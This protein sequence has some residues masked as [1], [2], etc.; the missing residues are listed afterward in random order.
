MSHKPLGEILADLDAQQRRELAA[1]SKSIDEAERNRVRTAKQSLST[2]ATFFIERTWEEIAPRIDTFSLETE[3]GRSTAELRDYLET[4]HRRHSSFAWSWVRAR[5]NARLMLW[6]EEY[7]PDL[8]AQHPE[9]ATLYADSLRKLDF[10]WFRE[11]PL[12]HLKAGYHTALAV[13][14]KWYG[15]A[16]EL[17]HDAP[18]PPCQ[19]TTPRFRDELRQFAS[20]SLTM[21]VRTDRY[22]WDSAGGEPMEAIL[23]DGTIKVAHKLPPELSL[24]TAPDYGL[25]L[26]CPALRARRQEGTPAFPGIID[27]VE[28]VFTDY[29]TGSTG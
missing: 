14:C 27:W 9:R 13:A 18:H 12:H 19:H 17:L 11:T 15:S 2:L 29:L 20:S 10:Y 23:E 6:L 7:V 5:M 26:G 1:L 16:H 4:L 25:R 24:N 8:L 21:L 28:Q 3:S 22:L